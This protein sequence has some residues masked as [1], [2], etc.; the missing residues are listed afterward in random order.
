MCQDAWQPFAFLSKKL[1]TAE[2]KCSAYDTELLA[3]YAAVKY[4]GRV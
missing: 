3:I 2:Q 4:A 1:S